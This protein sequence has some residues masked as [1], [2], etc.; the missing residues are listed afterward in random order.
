MST[1]LF[2]DIMKK[3]TSKQKDFESEFEESLNKRGDGLFQQTK[4]VY[5]I[6]EN[7]QSDELA[8]HQ[9]DREREI[10]LR[11]RGQKGIKVDYGK[12]LTDSL[13]IG[14]LNYEQAQKMEANPKDLD[15]YIK[16]LA[17]ENQLEQ[18][19][20]LVGIRK[21]LTLPQDPL[22]QEVIDKT[23]VFVL[24]NTLDHQLPEFQYEAVSCIS[25][26]TS[27]TSDQIKS[28]VSKGAHKKLIALCDSQFFE[29]Q[30]QAVWGVGNLAG[31]S[32]AIRDQ[33]I[34]DGALNKLYY[35]LNNCNRKSL[36]KNIV[37]AF[38]N[39]CKGKNAPKFETISP[40]SQ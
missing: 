25:A 6:K 16:N 30:E 19:F 13:T 5:D 34:N 38:S 8:R 3:Q 1:N 9:I 2:A 18:Y 29:I 11:R 33:L 14:A 27:G 7:T 31:E 40:V 37:W 4:T 24:V 17:S 32:C 36:I 35:Y 15:N 20:G 12:S 26:I 22:I 23:I 39:F 21:L 28:V 10:M